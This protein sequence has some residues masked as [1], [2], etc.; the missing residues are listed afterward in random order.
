[1]L[2]CTAQKEHK[3][4]VLEIASQSGKELAS[5]FSG[6]RLIFIGKKEK[7]YDR[8]S[9]TVTSLSAASRAPEEPFMITDT[10]ICL[11]RERRRREITLSLIAHSYE[12]NCTFEIK[13]SEFIFKHILVSFILFVHFITSLMFAQIH[14]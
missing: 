14:V 6:E 1:M 13:I 8:P 12:K 10:F 7:K 3:T 5:I 9:H 4:H 11:T 2:H